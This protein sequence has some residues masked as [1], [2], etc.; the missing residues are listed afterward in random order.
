MTVEGAV[1]RVE[2][3]VR[4]LAS[5]RMAIVRDGAERENEGDLVMAADLAT[6]QGLAFMARLAGGLICVPITA[7]R[8]GMLRLSPISS[9]NTTPTKTAFLTPVDRRG[10]TTGISTAERAAT[11]RGLAGSSGPDAFL[12][13]GHIFPLLA[14]ERGLGGREG[15]T[16]AAVELARLAG[17]APAAVICEILGDDGEP[18]RGPA[19]EAF[20]CRHG[21]PMVDIADIVSYLDA[22][23]GTLRRIA[24]ANLP[25]ADGL[26]RVIVYREL[27]SGAEHLALRAGDPT[28][29]SP[30]ARLHSECLTGDTLGSLRCDCGAQLTAAF[31]IIGREG[32]I[33][34]YLR[35][36]G[37]GIGLGN[38]IRAYA[39]QDRGMD[40]VEANEAL[41]LPVDARDYSVGA[42]MLHDLG[43]HSVRLMT[44]NPEK[45]RGLE[46][47]GIQVDARVPLVPETSPESA[48]YLVTKAQR[49]G[50]MI[51]IHEKEGRRGTHV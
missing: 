8:A 26:F 38:K 47:R 29:A 42:A 28:V 36:E 50:H 32:G 23:H 34:L 27:A 40:T 7:E 19:L 31:E 45:V 21:L 25:T 3:A 37:R 13:P 16:E 35:Q 39:L 20:G 33:I 18:L 30:L 2:A 12:R 17:R 9:I 49:L 6:D 15:H 4:A 14:H 51:P 41:G 5:G 44:N 48:E 1:S 24:E 46:A 11:A 43:A 10:S 22:G